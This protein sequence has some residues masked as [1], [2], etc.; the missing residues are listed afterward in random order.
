MRLRT[1]TLGAVA[2]GLFVALSLLA[3]LNAADA[4]ASNG[5]GS[6]TPGRAVVPGGEHSF[7]TT[8]ADRL[9]RTQAAGVVVAVLAPVAY[10]DTVA[11]TLAAEILLL[12]SNVVNVYLPIVER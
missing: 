10:T 5:R 7:D 1:S 8:A 2:A 11:A 6:I 3:G 4:R 12:G 9:L